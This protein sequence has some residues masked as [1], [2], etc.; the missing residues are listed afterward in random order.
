MPINYELRER[1]LEAQL[2]A[3]KARTAELK[4]KT[5]LYDDLRDCLMTLNPLLT[6]IVAEALKKSK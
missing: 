2:E 4:A 5:A 3:T 6:S 1:L